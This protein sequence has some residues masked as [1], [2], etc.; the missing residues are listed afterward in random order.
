MQGILFV[1]AFNVFCCLT[2]QPLYK[3]EKNSFAFA[4]GPNVIIY[5]LNGNWENLVPVTLSEDRTKI[6]AYPGPL[7]LQKM[8]PPMYLKHGWW[9]DTRGISENTAFLSIT[10]DEYKTYKETLSLEEMKQKIKVLKPFKRMY[11]CGNSIV[12]E[13]YIDKLKNQLRKKSI[14]KC[15]CVK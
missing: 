15:T 4:P 2:Q 1:I 12:N 8:K 13:D 5:Q 14:K 6:V 9:L 3:S 7:D 10:L 11:N